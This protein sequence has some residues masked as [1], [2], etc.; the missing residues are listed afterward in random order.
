MQKK[1]EK[2][3]EENNRRVEMDWCETCSK[4]LSNSQIY[5]YIL[6]HVH[7]INR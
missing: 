7:L 4:S 6:F 2:Q 5:R 3:R 1:N